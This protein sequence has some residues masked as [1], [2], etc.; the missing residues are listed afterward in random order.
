MWIRLGFSEKFYG[1]EKLQSSTLEFLLIQ[2]W[3]ENY[4]KKLKR[5]KLRAN[6]IQEVYNP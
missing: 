6:L 4:K 3:Q 1:Q 2:L 5:L